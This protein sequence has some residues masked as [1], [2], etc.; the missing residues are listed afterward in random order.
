MDH[1][2]SRMHNSIINILY[3]YFRD[4]YTGLNPGPVWTGRFFQYTILNAWRLSWATQNSK[5]LTRRM[6]LHLLLTQAGQSYVRQILCGNYDQYP[7]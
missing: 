4:S 3:K 1:K 7:L 2:Y 6:D 5:R